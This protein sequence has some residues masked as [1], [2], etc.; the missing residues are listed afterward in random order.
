VISN[1]SISGGGASA[2]SGAVRPQRILIVRLS[3]L[4]DVIQTLP[5]PT[6]IRRSYPD[7]RVG[8][9]IDSE[10]ASAIEGHPHVDHI[11]RCDRNR[12]GSEL[13]NPLNWPSLGRQMTRLVHE[14]RDAKYDVAID[15]QGFLKSAIIP[16]F[17]GIRRRVGFAHWREMSSLFYNE[18]HISNEEYF[19]L[20]HHHVEHM[21]QLAAAIGCDI[22]DYSIHL[23]GI[24]PE[25]A[26]RIDALLVGIPLAPLVAVAPGTQWSSKLWPLGHW[27]RLMERILRETPAGVV[28][29]GSEADAAITSELMARLG[30]AASHRVVNIAGRTSLRDLYALFAR[31]TVTI[32]SDT[33][34]L[35]VAAAIGSHPVVGLFGSTSGARTGP[36]G[37][38]VQRIISVTPSLPC[39]PCLERVCRFGTNECMVSISPDTVFQSLM[40]VLN[41]N[42]SDA[43]RAR[44]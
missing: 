11:H 39:Q 9:V 7:A 13:A 26:A 41:D 22:S 37:S 2:R 3:S 1:D 28:L 12:W 16:F 24:D 35:H 42:S 27:H 14:I 40:E 4:G 25:A 18:K 36:L 30:E 34:P 33:A 21:L 5:I 29:S 23:P 10:L 44:C 31:V 20:G 38:G 32:A 17:A 15:A 6:V 8:W 43:R 19:N